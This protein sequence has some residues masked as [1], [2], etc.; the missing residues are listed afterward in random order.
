MPR[1]AW[2]GSHEQR[3]RHVR[4]NRHFRLMNAP[5]VVGVV[6]ETAPGER[7]V[8]LAPDGVGRLRAAGLDVVVERGAGPRPGT[9]TRPTPPRARLGSKE[10]VYADADVVVRLHPPADRRPGAAAARPGA[11][12]HCS[13][14]LTR[15]ELATALARGEGDGGQPG[16]A[17]P[18]AQPRAV[19]G[20]AHLAGQRRRLQGGAG[21]SGRLRRLLPDADDSGRHHPAGARCSCS[22]PGVAGLQ[23]H[24]HGPPARRASSPGTTCGEAARAEV[25]VDRARGPRRSARRAVGERRGRLRPGADRRGAGR[26]SRQALDAAIGRFDIVITTAQVPGRR[27]AGAGVAAAALRGACGPARWSSTSPR[28]TLG[29]NVEGSVPDTTIVTDSGV[30][31]SAPATCRPPC[32]RRRPPRT[33][34]TSSRCWPT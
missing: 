32:P 29:G 26:R 17:A 23:A 3:S 9:R 2:R 20:R 13:Q 6:R 27:A 15:P 28:A 21:G 1:R 12:R 5:L 11:G 19:D 31:S 7:R 25:A 33:P 14:P 10:E 4:R 16:R 34:A 22:A 24:R 18:H 8:A 30:T